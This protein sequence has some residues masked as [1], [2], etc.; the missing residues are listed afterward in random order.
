[1]PEEKIVNGP[2]TITKPDGTKETHSS[3]M[4]KGFKVSQEG[5][6]LIIKEVAGDK[7]IVPAANERV[8]FG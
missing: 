6:R 4:S 1:M 2:L 8:E 5:G 3:P 7:V